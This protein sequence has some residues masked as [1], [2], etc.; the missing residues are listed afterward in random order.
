[1]M[2][3]ALHVASNSLL[4]TFLKKRY[5]LSTGGCKELWLSEIS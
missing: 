1:M 3:G 4:M 5:E 2:G